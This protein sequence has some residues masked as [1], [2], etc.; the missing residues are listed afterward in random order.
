[1]NQCCPS[2]HLKKLFQQTADT[3]KSFFSKLLKETTM[4]KTPINFP[5]PV[6][7]ASQLAKIPF[8]AAVD[9]LLRE[10]HDVPGLRITMHRAVNR[11]DQIYLQQVC[12]YITS[13]G[14]EWR[15][16]VGRTFAVSEGIMEAAFASGRIWPNML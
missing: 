4:A 13:Q 16:K 12:G 15:G 10:S 1:V 9:G 6:P 2:R 7:P 5:E 14:L 11:E 3:S 8:L